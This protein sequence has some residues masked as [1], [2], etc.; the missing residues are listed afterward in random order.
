[1]TEAHK[2]L[3]IEQFLGEWIELIQLKSEVLIND[4]DVQSSITEL[5]ELIYENDKAFITNESESV[6]LQ[7]SDGPIRIRLVDKI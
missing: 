4:D 6:I 1:M 5:T 2:K 7:R 3:I